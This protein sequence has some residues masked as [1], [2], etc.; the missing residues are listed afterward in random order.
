[1]E[2]SKNIHSDQRNGNLHI[3]LSGEFSHDMAMTVSYHILK[4]YRGAGNIFIHTNDITEVAPRSQAVFGQM[5]G[6]LDLPRE[7][8]YL[9]GE[10]GIDIGYEKAKVLMPRKKKQAGCSGCGNCKCGAP[11]AGK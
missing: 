6:L 1:M 11:T 5:I 10:K 4:S 3:R 2:Q 9:M 8:I 7:H